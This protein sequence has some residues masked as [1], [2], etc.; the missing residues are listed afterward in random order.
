MSGPKADGCTAVPLYRAPGPRTTIVPP[1]CPR[2]AISSQRPP[3]AT[4]R[5]PE[6]GADFEPRATHRDTLVMGRSPAPPRRAAPTGVG[7][8]R[9]TDRTRPGGGCCRVTPGGMHPAQRPRRLG[10][11]QQQ[12]TRGGPVRPP[13]R[14]HEGRQTAWQL[15]RPRQRTRRPSHGSPGSCGRSPSRAEWISTGQRS[16]RLGRR[17]RLDAGTLGVVAVRVDSAR[18]AIGLIRRGHG[19]GLSVLTADEV[20][21]DADVPQIPV[22]IDGETVMLPT[23]SGA[24]FGPG[25]LRVV[26]PRERPG[27]PAPRRPWNG[28]GCGGS[29]P[30]APSRRP[31]PPG[32][33]GSQA[34][35]LGRTP[36]LGRPLPGTRLRGA[37]RVLAVSVRRSCCATVS[38]NSWACGRRA[39]PSTGTLMPS[40]E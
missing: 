12:T 28:R 14:R 15:T 24:P 4:T 36:W 10:R 22:G 40:P 26:V 25:A 7:A 27:V 18:Q 38:R 21:V 31:C 16:V 23:R 13:A 29:R 9:A 5:K 37:R 32:Q 30:S 20:T 1:R 8:A 19:P 6:A 3:P 35:K 34:C 17:A 33:V 11:R 39:L 2:I